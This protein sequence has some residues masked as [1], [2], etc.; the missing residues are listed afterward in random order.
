MGMKMSTGQEAAA[1]HGLA[2]NTAHTPWERMALALR[3]LELYE[4]EVRRLNRLV[5]ELEE[6]LKQVDT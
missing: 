1:F 2:L 4:L 3:A 5:E 6:Q